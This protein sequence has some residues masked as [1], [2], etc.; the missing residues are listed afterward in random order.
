M[1]PVYNTSRGNSLFPHTPSIYGLGPWDAS[2]LANVHPHNLEIPNSPAD[3]HSKPKD[4]F[5][6]T[7]P[8][9]KNRRMIR[10]AL[11]KE[12]IATIKNIR[13][14]N[15]KIK[16]REVG[17]YE[18]KDLLIQVGFRGGKDADGYNSKQRNYWKRRNMSLCVK[19]GKKV[20]KKNPQTG[21][22]YRLCDYHRKK[23][24]VKK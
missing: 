17:L 16:V 15:N 10:M 2:C 22:V 18:Y 3:L 19:C 8:L 1:I 14:L 21:K 4:L 13:T 11:K 7:P 23:I 6:S 24:D 9:L 20:K 12:K 5:V